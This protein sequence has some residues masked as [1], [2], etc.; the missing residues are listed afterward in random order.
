MS[1]NNAVKINPAVRTSR[2]GRRPI[3]IPNNVKF[4]FK[5]DGVLTV[6]GPKGQL[7]SK[8]SHL[9]AVAVQDDKLSFASNPQM[10]GDH[11]CGTKA[12]LY[13]SIV[14]TT[15]ANIANMIAGVTAGF[16]KKLLLIGVGYRAQMQG[17]NLALSLGFSRPVNFVV[18]HGVTIETPT[19]TEILIKG[20]DKALVGLV[21]AKIRQIRSPEPYKG[22]GVRYAD[23]KI[24]LK[25]TKKK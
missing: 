15:R 25:E 4:D 11:R 6:T 2:I 23:E 1:I 16:E 13:K 22:K 18:P 9:V 17:A 21:A 5:E 3:I 8:L 24:I 19:Q 14:G 7:S 20:S 12:K 10:A